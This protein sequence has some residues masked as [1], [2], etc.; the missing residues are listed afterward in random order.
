MV[1]SASDIYCGRLATQMSVDIQVRDLSTERSLHA[2]ASLTT[3]T[4]ILI[5]EGES[6][7]SLLRRRHTSNRSF[8]VNTTAQRALH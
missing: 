5:A 4:L 6:K 7:I 2:S 8:H 1:S 3:A